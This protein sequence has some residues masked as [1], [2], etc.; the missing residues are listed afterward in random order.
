VP[1]NAVKS[2]TLSAADAVVAVKNALSEMTDA[3]N[4][5]RSRR[6][7]AGPPWWRFDA[8]PVE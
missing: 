7:I 5:A 3:K 1:K 2:L 6:F 4:S 8:S